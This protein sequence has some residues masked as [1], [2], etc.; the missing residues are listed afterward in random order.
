MD[1]GRG[2]VLNSRRSGVIL[3]PASQILD[4]LLLGSIFLVPVV[5]G[6]GPQAKVTGS[7]CSSVAQ[8][9][10]G[11]RLVQATALWF[12]DFTNLGCLVYMAPWF[13]GPGSSGLPV[14]TCLSQNHGCQCRPHRLPDMQT[15][16][17]VCPGT[18][19]RRTVRGARLCSSCP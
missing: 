6:F 14:L 12:F 19:S 8:S 5:L 2:T 7:Y 11:S 18:C 9:R 1:K 4:R 16:I 15:C 10:L 3:I 13:C 17:T